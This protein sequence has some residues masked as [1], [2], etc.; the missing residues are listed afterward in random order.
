MKTI[1]ESVAAFQRCAG[2]P[3]PAK[4]LIPDDKLRDLGVDLVVEEFNELMVAIRAT[5]MEAGDSVD[6]LTD[7]A[8]ALAD[9]HYVVAW[10]GNV[11]GLPMEEIFDEVQRSNM[12]KFPDGKVIRD[13]ANGKILKPEDWTP[14]DIRSIIARSLKAGD[15][16]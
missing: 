2:I 11:W 1:R 15:E 7:V 10:V 6:L 16:E 5:V 3:L 13:P 4:P 12:A 8:D 9:L 14:P